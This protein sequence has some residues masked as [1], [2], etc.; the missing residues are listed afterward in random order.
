MSEEFPEKV[1]KN[2]YPRPEWRFPNA[3][4]STTYADSVPDFPPPHTAPEGSPNILLVL[5]DDV[6]FGWPSVFG[7]LI[8]MSTAERLA[9]DGLLYNQFHTTAL[10]SPTRAASW[11]LPG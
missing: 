2:V 5:I 6:G 9:G 8:E 7:G 10:C 3:K 4:T 11:Q 1:G